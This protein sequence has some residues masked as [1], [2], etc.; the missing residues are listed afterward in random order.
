MI[1]SVFDSVEN[2]VGKEENAGYQ[3]FVLF[4]HCFEKASF[5]EASK[6]HCLGMGYMDEKNIMIVKNMRKSAKNSS[7]HNV[8]QS[9]SPE[10]GIFISRLKEYFRGYTGIVRPCVRLCTKYKFLSKCWLGIKSHLVI[11]LVDPE[12][13]CP[14]NSLPYSSEF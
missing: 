9:N 3:H 7:E 6:G 13:R 1:I 5:P 2:M 8:L 14:F 10:G 12:L 4:P 11:A